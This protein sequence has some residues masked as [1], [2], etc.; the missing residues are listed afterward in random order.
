MY[1][2]LVWYS[3]LSIVYVYFMLEKT[4]LDHL[5]LNGQIITVLYYCSLV[6]SLKPFHFDNL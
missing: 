3:F 4:C 5:I 6:T 1:V 2:S